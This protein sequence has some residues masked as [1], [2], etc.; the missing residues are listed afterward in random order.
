LQKQEKYIN[1][2]DEE[3]MQKIIKGNSVCYAEIY[4]RYAT[5][6]LNYFYK[7][8]WKDREKAEDFLHDLF[9]KIIAKPDYFDP[10]RSFKTWIFSVA[11]NMCKN[12]YKKQEIR[13]GTNLELNENINAA[14]N[15]QLVNDTDME[16]FNKKLYEEL[17]NLGEVQ[18]A[19]FVL[20]Y[21]EDKSIKEI[22]EI[23]DCSEG[24][25]KSRLFYALKKISPQL[26]M[27]N[28]IETQYTDEQI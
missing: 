28:P 25:V 8:L 13:K 1:L 18:K 6:L 14:E 3:L 21:K 9:A 7:M 4:D 12:E 27:Y 26:K 5:K 22:S 16:M 19:S 11:N 17:D 20:R 15:Q 23:M 10:K 2:S 24:T